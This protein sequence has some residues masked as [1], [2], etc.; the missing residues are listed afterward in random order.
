[1]RLSPA[2]HR[3]PVISLL[4][5]SHSLVSTKPLFQLYS[6]LL[7]T[8]P[9]SHPFTHTPTFVSTSAF[10]MSRTYNNISKFDDTLG[11]SYRG[12]ESFKP[13]KEDISAL[14]ARAKYLLSNHAILP[15]NVSD[16]AYEAATT[17][18]H[19]TCSIHNQKVVDLYRNNRVDVYG[20]QSLCSRVTS[21]DVAEMA[22]TI[23][24]IANSSHK[25]QTKRERSQS[26]GSCVHERPDE[27]SHYPYAVQR[28]SRTKMQSGVCVWCGVR[29]LMSQPDRPILRKRAS[30]TDADWE[31]WMR[32]LAS[33]RG[34]AFL[35]NLPLTLMP[36]HEILQIIEPWQLV[37]LYKEIASAIIELA[38]RELRGDLEAR[39]IMAQVRSSKY[40]KS[41]RVAKI[42][43]SVY[44]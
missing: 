9:N 40:H 25:L 41:N 2:N 28:K 39:S 26:N 32:E 23:D 34:S 17:T 24:Y 10:N 31:Q 4:F 44:E 30:G 3:L 29:K 8:S 36:K 21:T 16:Y 5:H 13:V 14:L 1:M 43:E 6:L 33:P 42:I 27:D 18:T 22:S 38:L 11:I 19:A 15:F 35:R 12:V 37:A 20:G 7:L